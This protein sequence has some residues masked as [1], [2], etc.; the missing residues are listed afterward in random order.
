MSNE[1]NC[2]NC[3]QKMVVTKGWNRHEGGWGWRYDDGYIV[4]EN[5]PQE[6]A[7]IG[8]DKHDDGYIYRTH[9][10][11]ISMRTLNLDYLPDI[12]ESV[13]ETEVGHSRVAAVI[14]IEATRLAND[15]MRFDPRCM[16][17][18]DDNASYGL[19]QTLITTAQQMVDDGR[20]PII[21]SRTLTDEDLYVPRIS[22]ACGVAYMDY[23]LD[24]YND[25]IKA[26]VAA[27]NAGSLKTTDKNPWHMLTYS[28]HR[29]DR[30]MAWNNDYVRLFG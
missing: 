27:Y 21:S 16:R 13:W 19:M 14:A 25:D 28:P 11:P 3:N 8:W 1:F 24:R 29:I 26:F 23:Q 10:E 2:P 12:A 6:S 18:E 30:Y 17:P 22:I 4:A 9:G 15:S 5:P 7:D 20:V